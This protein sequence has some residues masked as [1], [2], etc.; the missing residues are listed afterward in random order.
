MRTTLLCVIPTVII[1]IVSIITC[2]YGYTNNSGLGAGNGPEVLH[3][4]AVSTSMARALAQNRSVG[5]SLT[6]EPK[7]LS[8][9]I[10]QGSLSVP[11]HIYTILY[12]V[13]FIRGACVS[14][15]I[16]Q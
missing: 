11:E 16:G 10:P 2:K 1:V 12:P 14:P 3:E 9:T 15:S 4:R 6:Q 5:A 8:N 13:L 7:K